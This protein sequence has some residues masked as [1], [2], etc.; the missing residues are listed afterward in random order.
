MESNKNVTEQSKTTGG[1]PNKPSTT[2]GQSSIGES[3]HAGNAPQRA[4]NRF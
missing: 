3:G 2:P 1:N 4:R